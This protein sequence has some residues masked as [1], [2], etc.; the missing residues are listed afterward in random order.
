[1]KTPVVLRDDFVIY[2][3]WFNNLVFLHTDVYRWTPEIK[4][5]F[6][7]ELNILQSLLNLPLYGLVDNDKLGKFGQSIGFTYGEDVIGNDGNSYQ[8]Y[9]RSL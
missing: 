2:I 7:R 6:I 3:E 8:I 1:M 5:N 4:K 9:Y